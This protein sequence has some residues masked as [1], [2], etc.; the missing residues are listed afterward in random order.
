V[1]K[2]VTKPVDTAANKEVKEFTK[3]EEKQEDSEKPKQD[4]ISNDKK[5]DKKV[6]ETKKDQDL[7]SQKKS[8][9][10]QEVSN[11]KNEQSNAES[12]KVNNIE[13]IDL[14]AREKFNIQ[15]QLKRCYSR[16]VAEIN[17]K[18]KDSV[19]IQV[20]INEEGVIDY[21]IEDSIDMEK[22]DENREYKAAVDNAKRAIDLCSPLRNLPTDKYDVWKEVV[23]NF[24][25]TKE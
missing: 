15:S 8:E 25:E 13:N 12:S 1:A 22:Y 5:D 16:S 17:Y 9:E 20:S 3:P 23:L 14:S 2:S 19:M 18:G 4:E 7:G 11:K 24:G 10:V 6:I 21:D